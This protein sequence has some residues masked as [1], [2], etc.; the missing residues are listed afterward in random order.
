[1]KTRTEPGNPRGKIF[2]TNYSYSQVIASGKPLAMYIAKEKKFVI[3][4]T[5]PQK[6]ECFCCSIKILKKVRGSSRQN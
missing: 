6:W 4:A 1:M 2:T 3:V 5:V